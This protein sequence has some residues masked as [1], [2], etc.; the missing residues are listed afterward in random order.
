M[1]IKGKENKKLLSILLFF[2]K[3]NILAIPMY[4]IIW[5]NLNFYLIE[6]IQAYQVSGFL[7]IFGIKSM[8]LKDYIPFISMQGFDKDIGI[9]MACT[10][11]RSLF[12]LIALIFAFPSAWKKK[13]K[14]IFLFIPV[15]WLVN[16]I[17]IGTTILAGYGF[18]IEVFDITHLFLWRE[19]LVFLIL[20]LW[21]IW[22]K[23]IK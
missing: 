14:G 23:K 13:L 9:D 8:V 22:I 18:G 21:I 11:Y 20:F 17:R 1:N 12:L 15:V 2:F 10:G 7:N 16:I 5:F 19:G 6:E 3:L 4:V